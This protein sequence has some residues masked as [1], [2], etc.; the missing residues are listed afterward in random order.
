[1]CVGIY[2]V[3]CDICVLGEFV[4]LTRSAVISVS[5][6]QVSCKSWVTSALKATHGV[7]TYA[8]ITARRLHT[9]VDVHFT[10]LTYR[11]G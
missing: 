10:R 4:Y 1:M 8:A 11:V 7:H 5:L 6:T 9:L 2:W 3:H